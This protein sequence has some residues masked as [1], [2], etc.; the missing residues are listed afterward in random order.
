MIILLPRKAGRIIFQSLLVFVFGVLLMSCKKDSF[1]T[2]AAARIST[3]VDTLKYD[4]VFTSIGSITK[5]FKISNLNSQKLRLSKLQL[6]GGATSSFKINING[7]AADE[8][9]GIEI[10]AGDSLY[11]FV[12]AHINPNTTDLPFIVKDSILIAYNGNEKFVQLEAFGQNAN[13]LRNR[14][15]TS[16]TRWTNRLPYV[17]LGSLLVAPSAT[18]T[19]DPGCKIYVHADAPLIVDGSLIVNGT[20][21]G[22]VTFNGDRLDAGYRDLPAGWPG[23]Y[24]RASSK[25]NVLSHAIIKNAYQAIAVEQPATNASPKLMLAKCIIDNAYDAGILGVNTSIQAENCLITNCVNNVK[26]LYGGNYIMDHCTLASYPAFVDHKDPVLTVSNYFSQNGAAISADLKAS[27]RN[28]IFWGEGNMVENEVK[29]DKQGVGLFEVI[30]DHCLFKAAVE[31]VN[32]VFKSSVKN[33]EPLFDSIDVAARY[34]DFRIT[35]SPASPVINRG[36]YTGL[37][38]DLDGKNR[39]VGLPDLGCY[40]KQ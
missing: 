29:V 38:L 15:I 30:F 27:F 2:S 33:Q 28:C 18:L 10:E 17:I 11:V 7:I 9:A 39:N 34:F 32:A 22:P 19:I 3:S 20:P 21:T 40:E 25:D 23:I 31:P 12:E 26:L 13:F 5:S 16:N 35:K 24:F 14:I 1:I 8:M 4:T 36:I 6:M 37:T